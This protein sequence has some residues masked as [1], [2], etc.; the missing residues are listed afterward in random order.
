MPTWKRLLLQLYYRAS[1]PA[2]RCIYRYLRVRR[3]LPIAVLYYHRVA[4]DG[5]SEWTMPSTLFT[6]QM[7]WLKRN[8][9]L[10]SMDEVQRRIRH[11]NDRPAVHITF[12][13][14][15]SANCQTAVP[16]LVKE[17]IPCTYFVTWQNV[18]EQRAFDHDR[19]CGRP[20]AVNNVKQLRA[21]SHA[22]IE[23]GAHT[24]S[25][26]DVGRLTDPLAVEKEIVAAR[27]EL[28]AAIGWPVR[29]FAF[30]YGMLANMSRA[31]FAKATECGYEA[32]CSAYGGLN[33]PG[34]QPF[35]IQRMPADNEF[36]RLKNWLTGDPRKLFVRR[37][38][39]NCH[40]GQ[41]NG[42][43]QTQDKIAKENECLNDVAIQA[44]ES[45]HS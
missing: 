28:A 43:L 22:G 9:D 37:Y 25:H 41:G 16:L 1:M 4:D 6:E 23:I 36:I 26:A 40:P 14:G 5:A 10:I 11:G 42:Q 12:D 2:R 30:P 35:H 24:W 32:V 8:F 19:M 31:A 20:L 38:E 15:Y 44:A 21:M 7:M 13:D 39:Y 29:Y 27:D 45:G 18:A 34:D 33:F 17:R 3:R